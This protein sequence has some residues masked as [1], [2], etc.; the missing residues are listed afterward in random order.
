MEYP[1]ASIIPLSLAR[2]DAPFAVWLVSRE[3]WTDIE[4]VPSP[5]GP[6]GRNAATASRA[7][8]QEA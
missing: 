6:V 2:R 8:R 3:G 5:P 1:M 7:A 4:S